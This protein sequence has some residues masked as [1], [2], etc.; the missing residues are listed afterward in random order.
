MKIK[1]IDTSQQAKIFA[2][3]IKNEPKTYF[4]QGAWG[5]GKTEYLEEVKKNIGEEYSFIDLALWKPKRKATF[6]EVIFEGIYPKLNKFVEIGGV[7]LTIA[8]I[9]GVTI[10]SLIGVFYSNAIQN[11]PSKYLIIV[12]TVSVILS[13]LY[14][15][16]QSKWIDLDKFYMNCSIKRL[17]DVDHPVVLVIDDFDR[18]DKGLQKELYTL[19]NA[20]HEK[21][22]IIFVGD[23]NKIEKVEDNYLGKI[24]DQK[25]A[26]PFSLHSRNIVRKVQTAIEEKVKEEFDFTAVNDLFIDE[27]LTLRDANQYL[28]YVQKEIINQ[29]KIGK[30]QIDQQLFVIYLY[31]FHQSAYKMLT[32]GWFPENTLKEKEKDYKV[33]TEV[34]NLMNKIFK[35]RH[36]NPADFIRNS[37]VY[38]VDELANNHSILELRNIITNETKELT[39]F[40]AEN[41]KPHSTDFDEFFNYVQNM[42]SEEYTEVQSVLEKHAILTMKSEVRHQPNELIKYVFEQRNRESNELYWDLRRKS[43]KKKEILTPFEEMFIKF[44]TNTDINISPSEKMYYFHSCLNLVGAT[45]YD[46]DNLMYRDIPIVNTERVMSHFLNSAKRIEMESNFGERDYD[47]EAIIVQIGYHFWKRNDSYSDEISDFETK[48]TSIEKL[49]DSEYLAFWNEYFIRPVS[50]TTGEI[51]LSSGSALE[52]D[53]EDNCY[54]DIVLK[55]LIE[56]GDLL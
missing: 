30:V 47:A 41:T 50:D 55:K 16:M 4:L 13:T 19:F 31:L 14:N 40:F 46:S 12:T 1:K 9:I 26:L 43:N 32:D 11:T 34:L 54:E 29:N 27:H 48:A 2:E 22:R 42:R 56:M 53:Y 20:I 25:V 6:S 7:I 15:F 23:L 49:K 37:T 33:S 24:I 39:K 28:G 10:L 38:F 45:H 51:V 44:E 36:S 52:F 3:Q 5:S 8:S 17:K 35:T 21:T 18:L